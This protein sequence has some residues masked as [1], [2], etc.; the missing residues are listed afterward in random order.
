[1]KKYKFPI[2]LA[3]G[4][5]LVGV[6]LCLVV[7]MQIRSHIGAGVS[8]RA[9]EQMKQL[10][11]ERVSATPGA[12][13]NR[14][15]PVLSLD[16][17]DYV[18]LL[19]IPEMGLSF[20]VADRWEP[21][22]LQDSPARFCGSAY[23]HTLVIG[24]AADSHQFS[25]CNTVETGTLV[26]VTDMTGAHFTYRLPRVDRADSAQAQWLADP[27]YHLTLFCRGTYSMEYLAVRCRFVSG[28]Y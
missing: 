12:Y 11:P 21:D 28:G 9:L 13:P 8:Q 25:F 27:Q 17:R 20:P 2:L 18:A 23:D 4:I 5:V 7:G 19:E 26:T 22:K 15:M 24:G 1:M 10:L 3:V 14:N 16:G 6:S